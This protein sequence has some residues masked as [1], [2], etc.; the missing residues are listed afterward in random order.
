[1][2]GLLVSRWT[3]SGRKGEIWDDV[4]D[5]FESIPDY[6]VSH[7]LVYAKDYGVPQ[8]R[9]RVLLVGIRK[10]LDFRSLGGESAVD[11]GF[12]P[13]PTDEK[14]ADLVDLLGD[15]EDPNYENGGRTLTYPSSP[16]NETQLNLR[17]SK[18]GVT[19]LEKGD[20]IFDHEY[21]AHSLKIVQK[22][23]AMQQ[24]GGIIPEEFRT[25]KFAQRV[26]PARWSEGGPTITA[27]SLPD[28]YVHY[29]E[30]RSLT[31]RE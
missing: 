19:V 5:T 10:D 27:T 17:T 3:S 20:R 2:R 29:S 21:S 30:P 11:Q 4:R 16:Q 9:P 31:V 14:P 13:K 6:R 12:L 15:L 8:N 26:L 25:K 24:N 1:M 7:S 23:K 28:D 22:F 18:D